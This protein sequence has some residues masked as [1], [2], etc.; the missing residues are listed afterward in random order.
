MTW[1]DV[2]KC[3]CDVCQKI[4]T[5]EEAGWKILTL[6]RYLDTDLCKKCRNTKMGRDIILADLRKVKI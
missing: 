1:I 6:K 4:G 5:Y 3:R 2:K